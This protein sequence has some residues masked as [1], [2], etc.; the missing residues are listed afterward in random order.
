MILIAIPVE[1]GLG[2]FQG[3]LLAEVNLSFMWD[4]VDK[5]KV[6]QT[7]YAYVV[8][9]QGQLI[10]FQD[11]DR[12]LKSENEQ[13]INEVN[14]F[15]NSLGT[16]VDITPN[17]SSY[18]GLLGKT[19]VGTYSALGTPQWA[20]VT[21]LPWREAYSGVIQNVGVSLAILLAMAVLA[22]LAGTFVARRLAAPLVDLSHAAT[23]V[24]GG[25]LAVVAKQV[26]RPRSPK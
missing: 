4:L 17:V 2:H 22:G 7:G 10:A 1:D 16:S 15:V 26:G 13:K 3:T 14:K 5:I 18:T 11:T 6:G 24:A 8:D 25:N 9:G 19:V 21:E 12:V 23:E 20:V